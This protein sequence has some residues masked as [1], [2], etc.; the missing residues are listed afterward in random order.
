MVPIAN[1]LAVSLQIVAI[2]IAATAVCAALRISAPGL[3][4]GFWRSVLALCLVLPWLQTPTSVTR[5]T[6]PSI[7]ESATV[8]SAIADVS[9]T[10]P[11][12]PDWGFWLAVLIISGSCLRGAWIAIG[13]LKLG[14]LRRA[15]HPVP[16]TEHELLQ[17]VVGTR[18]DVE[19]AAAV[20][21][22]VTF[23]VMRPVVLLPVSLR[24][25]PAATRRAVIAHEL[26]HVRRRDWCWVLAE[27]FVRAL[28][29]FNPAIWWLISRVQQAREEVVDSTAVALTGN[30]REY[31]EALLAFA[32]DVPLAP[33][34][35]F[36]RRRHLFRRILLLS[37]ENAMS[38]RR[39]V[40]SAAIM[41]IVVAVAG[42]TAVVAFPLLADGEATS[43]QWT[44]AA[45]EQPPGPIEQT[46]KAVTGDNPVPKRVF[47]DVPVFPQNAQGEYSS[48]TVTLRTIVDEAGHVAEL[49]LAGFSFRRGGIGA[50]VDGGQNVGQRFEQFTLRAQFKDAQ[51]GAVITGESMRPMFEAFIEAAADA[52]QRWQYEPPPNGPIVFNT[53]IQF[54]DGKPTASGTAAAAVPRNADGAL[55]VGGAVSPPVKLKDVR[56]VYPQEAQDAG[57]QGVVILEVRIEG[58][59]RVSNGHV[60]RSIPMLDAAA[61]SAALQW[62]FTPTLLNGQ[63][64]PVIM[65]VTI[66]F[67]LQ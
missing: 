6:S 58:D 14:C 3:M 16:V 44:L 62:E 36:A 9:V 67:S 65:T 7:V 39:L 57:I 48:V 46:A 51:G 35:A 23:G 25:Q 41:A 28:L 43:Q 24:E 30:R 15:G 18:A 42:W 4:Y 45:L 22:P 33:A 55:R 12:T 38:A 52:V 34:P 26:V 50:T 53:V 40:A 2:A 31:V 10:T 56:P 37:K 59:G 32:D 47:G 21:Q 1:V 29:W 17:S 64:V 19:Y 66:Q 8:T 13:C 60:L 49:R 63:A 54:T 5:E 27:E 11:T 61:L 20:R